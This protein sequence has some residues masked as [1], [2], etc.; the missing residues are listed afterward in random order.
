MA[1]ADLITLFDEKI[2]ESKTL[3]I[4]HPEE[5]WKQIT[6]DNFYVKELMV[7]VYK[8]GKLVYNLPTLKE[9][10]AFSKADKETFWD[11]YKR[12]VNPQIYKVDLSK[13]LFN[14]KSSLLKK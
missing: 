1:I 3:T 11:E 7:Q 10:V 8:K 4:F 2:D 13:K 5:T 12:R 14:L 6:I 9:I